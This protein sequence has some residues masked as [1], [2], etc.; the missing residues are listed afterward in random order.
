MTDGASIMAPT[1]VNTFRRFAQLPGSLHGEQAGAS[2]SAGRAMHATSA[3]GA[4]GS[5]PPPLVTTKEPPMGAR[6]NVWLNLSGLVS[7]SGCAA[8]GTPAAHRGGCEVW[9]ARPFSRWPGRNHP[10]P[11]PDLK[12]GSSARARVCPRPHPPAAAR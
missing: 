10:A 12:E 1:V 3:G 8:S 5:R 11:V 7:P 6:W 4:R 2:S 9:L